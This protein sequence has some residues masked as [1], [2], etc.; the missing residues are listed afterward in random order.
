MCPKWGV[1]L[2]NWL[3]LCDNSDQMSRPLMDG[4]LCSTNRCGFSMYAGALDDWRRA[5][6]LREPGRELR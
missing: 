6:G 4:R 3:H 2:T 1:A 5:T